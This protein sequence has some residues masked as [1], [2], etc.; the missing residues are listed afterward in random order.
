MTRAPPLHLP[1]LLGCARVPAHSSCSSKTN[2]GADSSLELNGRSGRQAR[3][4][5]P[6]TCTVLHPPASAGASPAEP[7]RRPRRAA[8]P[9]TGGLWKGGGMSGVPWRPGC[10]RCAPELCPHWPTNTWGLLHS[11]VPSP[12][13][14]SHSVPLPL[15]ALHTPEVAQSLHPQ[16]W[17][18]PRPC[19]G[20]SGPGVMG[21]PAGSP[22]PSPYAH[23]SLCAH[24]APAVTLTDAQQPEVGAGPWHGPQGPPRSHI[25]AL[26]V[27]SHPS[28]HPSN[29]PSPM[30]GSGLRLCG[31]IGG[32]AHTPALM[33]STWGC[34][35]D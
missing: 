15:P 18:Q 14:L 4:R 3:H 22:L 25:R 6:P 19:Q 11:F 17:A 7:S 26:T 31:P 2:R 20:S 21:S 9:G 35:E 23:R 34:W 16:Q 13:V 5:R 24:T 10:P 12:P 29:K 1:G 32:Q 8:C 27:S 28:T 33:G 30:W